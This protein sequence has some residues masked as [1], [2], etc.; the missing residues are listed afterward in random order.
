MNTCFSLFPHL[1][2]VVIFASCFIQPVE[3]KVIYMKVNKNIH[4]TINKF[5]FYLDLSEQAVESW[6][7]IAQCSKVSSPMSTSKRLTRDYIVKLVI[8][9]LFILQ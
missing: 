7:F 4:V 9:F 6:H 5:S 3:G 2:V 1:F 8:N